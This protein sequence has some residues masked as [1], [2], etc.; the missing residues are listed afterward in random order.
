M[1]NR[2]QPR[3]G[4]AFALAKGQT[5][6]VIDPTGEQVAD[7]LAF[8]ARDHAEAISSGRSIDYAGKLFLSTGD[9]IYSNRSRVMLRIMEDTVGRHDFLLTPCS[10]DTFRL[11][12][13]D[14]LPHHG[15]QG[16]F[17]QALKPHGIT[18]D[19]IPVAFN[20]FMNVALDSQSGA[21]TV[22]PPRSKA[23][24]FIVFEAETDLLVALTA[25]SA[26]QSNNGSFKPIDFEVG[27]LQ[28]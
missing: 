3:T 5:L 10:S 23:G 9:S 25:C 24:D 16:N 14:E 22:Q 8:S 2:I 4:I 20:I 27:P 28:R 21:I 11:I 7:M 26:P 12:Y 15:C 19:Q 13:G 1:A 18:G 17:E 6:K